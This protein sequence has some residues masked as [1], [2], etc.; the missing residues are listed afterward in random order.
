MMGLN[1]AQI[2]LVASG[3]I[4]FFTMYFGCETKA[5][6]IKDLE[7]SRQLNMEVTSIDNLIIEARK[8]LNPNQLSMVE[9]MSSELEADTSKRIENLKLLAKTWFEYDNPVISGYYAEEVANKI[10]TPEA[11]SIAGTTF[12]FGIKNSKDDKAR[13]FSKQRAIR[14]IEKALTMEPENVN[15]KINLALCYVEKPDQ[16]N[17][18][19]GI[20]MLRELN[21]N[22]P[23]NVA[24]LNQ[25]AR[26]AIQTNQI[27]RAIQRLNEAIAIEPQNQ[28]TICLLAEV[29]EKAGD[30]ANQK[31]FSQKCNQ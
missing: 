20:L 9:T 4:L 14:A 13:E 15:H 19:K 25:L 21:T 23:Q 10:N 8:S 29:Y 7:K 12:I 6:N 24:V 28:T 17:P 22:N 16:D 2:I 11:W 26:L 5:K 3:V 18:M 27:E 31:I 1:K 30:A